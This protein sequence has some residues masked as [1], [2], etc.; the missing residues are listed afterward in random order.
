MSDIVHTCNN[1][2]CVIGH[3]HSGPCQVPNIV[4]SE[5]AIELGVEPPTFKNTHTCVNKDCV[6]GLVHDGP[7][8]T[9]PTGTP[10]NGG[11]PQY[12]ALLD[13]IRE[14]HLSKSHDYG[15]RDPLANLR[16]A[17]E[18][19]IRPW[20]GCLLR[21]NDKVTRIKSFIQSGTLKNESVEDSLLDIASYALL[22]LRLLREDAR[23][24]VPPQY[25]T[26]YSKDNPHP[27]AVKDNPQA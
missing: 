12:L 6:L 24:E 21:A 8:D 14:M 2:R 3:V 11:D 27:R 16:A 23:A 22:A 9:R 5:N 19:G 25:R 18:L 17:E 26:Q 13:E 7:C 1:P 10:I 20:I 15:F 4:F